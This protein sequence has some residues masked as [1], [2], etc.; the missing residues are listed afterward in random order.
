M[1]PPALGSAPSRNVDQDAAHHLRRDA[2]EMS[3]VLPPRLIP[4]EQSQADLV[5]ERGCLK[6]DARALAR[7]IAEGHAVQLVI[8]ERDELLERALVSLTP[9]AKQ[10]GNI[11]ARRRIGRA[12]PEWPWGPQCSK[13][14]IT[15]SD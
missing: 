9:H 13:A 14:G 10:T 2:K 15:G 12:H 4:P 6:R 11:A 3:A 1:V 8:D 7:E 5:D